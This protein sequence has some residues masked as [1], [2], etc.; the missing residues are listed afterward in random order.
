MSIVKDALPHRLALAIAELP[1]CRT[2]DYARVTRGERKTVQRTL[3]KMRAYNYLR[4]ESVIK[5]SRV[6]AL[7]WLTE[8]G[9]ALLDSGSP[10][11]LAHR[12]Q[13]DDQWHPQPWIHPIRARALGLTR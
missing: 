10:I 12:D 6:V 4:S 5:E 8:E 13:P 3:Q 2:S 7:W 11:T 9:Q 1:G